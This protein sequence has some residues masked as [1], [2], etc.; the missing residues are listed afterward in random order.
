MLT[1]ILIAIPDA[2]DHPFLSYEV[3]I[4]SRISAW[5]RV[6]PQEMIG[7]A[8]LCEAIEWQP[9]GWQHIAHSRN[10]KLCLCFLVTMKPLKH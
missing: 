5:P 9:L 10:P 3:S 6:H 2:L 8:V 7:C 4:A 1:E